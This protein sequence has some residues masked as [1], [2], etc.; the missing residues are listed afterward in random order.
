MSDEQVQALQEQ[1]VAAARAFRCFSAPGDLE[2]FYAYYEDQPDK[3]QA[4][5]QRGRDAANAF[6]TTWDVLAQQPERDAW[7]KALRPPL[8]KLLTSVKAAD[9]TFDRA[10]FDAL[11]EAQTSPTAGAPEAGRPDATSTPADVRAHL[12]FLAR[13]PV[14]AALLQKVAARATRFAKN[15]ATAQLAFRRTTVE[16]AQPVKAS[17]AI[18][19]S[20]AAVAARHGSVRWRGAGSFGFTGLTAKGG[21]AEGGWETDA[22]DEGENEVF[23]SALEAAGK[24]K[25]DVHCAFSCGSNWILYDPTRRTSRDEPAWGFVS[26]GD[27]NWVS[28]PSLDALDAGQVLLRLMAW[29]LAG[30]RGLLG[31]VFA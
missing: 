9:P 2:E 10:A 7:L 8:Q 24:K 27:C 1:I 4:V 17:P 14:D 28:L 22:L 25:N 11:L 30:E 6:R 31:D 5:I 13:S 12:A 20:Y 29:Q 21:F 16:L 18:P 15:G 3:Q 26:H 19:A 23:L